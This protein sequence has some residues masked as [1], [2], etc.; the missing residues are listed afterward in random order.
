MKISTI[1]L[2]A[3]LT[4]TLFGCAKVKPYERAHLADPIMELSEGTLSSLY[5]QH[6]QRALS[7]GL[8][9]MPVAGGGCGCEQ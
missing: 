5:E 1:S 8:I 4:I 6:M 3:I 2:T 9:G 7:Q